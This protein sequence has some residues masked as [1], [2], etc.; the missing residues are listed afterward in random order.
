MAR[1]EHDLLSC[2]LAFDQFQAE[3]CLLEKCLCPNGCA[4]PTAVSHVLPLVDLAT[5]SEG[6]DSNQQY[7]VLHDIDD[8]VVADSDA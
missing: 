6:D 5:M 1:A 3:S 2:R 8:P 4:R 7:V